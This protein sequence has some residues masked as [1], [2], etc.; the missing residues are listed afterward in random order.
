MY[1]PLAA[2]VR[3]ALLNALAY[4]DGD[5]SRAARYLGIS[6]RKL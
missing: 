2:V 4:T 1:G 5:Q 3:A 6:P